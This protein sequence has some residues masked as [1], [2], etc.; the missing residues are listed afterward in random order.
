VAEVLNMFALGLVPFSFYLLFLRAFYARQDAKTPTLINVVLNT[1]YA[2]FSLILFPAFHVQGLALAHSLCYLTGA[3]LAGLML[4]RR[5]GG[6]DRSRIAGALGRASLASLVAAGG[7]FL[8]VQTVNAVMGP[9]GER[10]LAQLVVGAAMGGVVFLGA[11]KLLRI[12]E[13]D[14]L[15]NLLPGRRAR[16]ATDL[17]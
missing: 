11:A 12:E 16:V 3:T 14:A 13:L 17:G 10:A 2:V 1:V 15:R 5:I 7:M 9:S 6:L 8:G 4:S